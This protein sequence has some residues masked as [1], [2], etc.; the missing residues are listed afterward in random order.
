MTKCWARVNR[1]KFDVQKRSEMRIDW[2]SLTIW[3]PVCKII[4][5]KKDERRSVLFVDKEIV[6]E[7]NGIHIFSSFV[8]LFNLWITSIVIYWPSTEPSIERC[9]CVNK[10]K[11]SGSRCTLNIDITRCTD[12]SSQLKARCRSENQRQTEGFGPS[13]THGWATSAKMRKKCCYGQKNLGQYSSLS[14]SPTHLSHTRNI[15]LSKIKC[16]RLYFYNEVY[17]F[18]HWSS[19]IIGWLFPHIFIYVYMYMYVAIQHSSFFLFFRNCF[20][21]RLFVLFREKW[22]YPVDNATNL[23]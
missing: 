20:Y 18:V 19:Y 23:F 14:P 2:I 22:Y 1:T 12:G 7:Q 4:S 6:N 8:Q 16:E 9:T 3:Q 17:L 10:R 11:N 15:T 5:R 21:F 13:V